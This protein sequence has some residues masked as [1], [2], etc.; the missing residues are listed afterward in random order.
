M[1][2][3]SLQ[4]LNQ[5]LFANQFDPTDLNQQGSNGDTALMKATQAGK[6]NIVRS[7]IVE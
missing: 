4:D 5:W 7:L 6:I 1:I 2:V 3:L